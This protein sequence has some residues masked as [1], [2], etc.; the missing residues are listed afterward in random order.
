MH[1]RG[2]R[3]DFGTPVGGFGLEVRADSLVGLIEAQL[4]P[5]EVLDYQRAG[6]VCRPWD[7]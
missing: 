6:C 2:T 3:E 1:S 5:G 7:T 4:V